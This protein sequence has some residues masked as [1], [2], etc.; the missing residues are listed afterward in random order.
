MDEFFELYTLVQLKKLGSEH[1]VPIILVNYD[2]FYDCLLTFIKT[3]I[4]QGTV[5]ENDITFITCLNT[6]DEVVDFLKSFYAL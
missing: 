4:E 2:G 1:K 3:M 5:G 6:N